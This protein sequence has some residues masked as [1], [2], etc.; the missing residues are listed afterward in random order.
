MER[1]YLQKMFEETLSEVEKEAMTVASVICMEGLDI[2]VMYSLYMPDCP[3]LLYDIV[4]S[5]CA[6]NLLFREHKRICCKKEISDAVL[7]VASVNERC[8]E[9]LLMSLEEYLSVGPLDDCLAR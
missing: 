6:R 8:L 9:N 2:E 3:H 5:L 1:N 7:E 4:D